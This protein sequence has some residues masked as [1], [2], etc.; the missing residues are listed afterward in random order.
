MSITLPILWGRT[1]RNPSEGGHLGSISDYEIK[2]VKG[3]HER[4]SIYIKRNR[5]NDQL[6]VGLLTQLVERCTGI[7]EV[8]GFES[9]KA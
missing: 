7:A 3:K 9:R 5:P 1:L 2:P 6:P 4:M 8:I